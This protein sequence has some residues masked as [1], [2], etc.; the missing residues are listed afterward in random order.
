MLV[1]GQTKCALPRRPVLEDVTVA[2]VEHTFYHGVCVAIEQYTKT[3]VKDRAIAA[4]R[5]EGQVIGKPTRRDNGW[6]E[7]GH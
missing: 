7:P 4:L 3:L 1:F 6:Q 5:L 2:E